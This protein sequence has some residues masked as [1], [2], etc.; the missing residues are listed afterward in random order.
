MKKTL[1]F[2]CLVTAYAGVLLMGCGGRDTPKGLE[3]SGRRNVI[4]TGVDLYNGDPFG[5]NSP[6]MTVKE[7]RNY[8]F[9]LQDLGVSWV[10]DALFRRVIEPLQG[11]YN[12]NKS[13]ALIRQYV[14]RLGLQVL[15]GAF[16]FSW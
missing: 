10:S 6:F 14:D 16:R 13:D 2:T 15:L 11:Q 9:L 7:L 8:G 4:P 5:I 12:F 1:T 3:G